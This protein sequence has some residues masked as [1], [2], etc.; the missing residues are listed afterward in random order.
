VARR[1]GH[2]NVS[3]AKGRIQGLAFDLER[4]DLERVDGSLAEHPVRSAGEL[5][6]LQHEMARLRVERPLIADESIDVVVS[7]C[8]LNLVATADKRHRDPRARRRAVTDRRRDRASQHDRPRLQRFGGF[9]DLPLMEDLALSRRLRRRGRI[10]TVNARV[11]VSGRR[12]LERPVYYTLVV[13]LFPL[14]R[15]L[16]VPAARL[17]R[18][19]GDPR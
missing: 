9:P 14:L 18:H 6:G 4:V 3:F 8:V 1:I 5:V 17:A 7:S 13:N 16:G 2:D 15:R 12:F 19:D 10:R 11:R